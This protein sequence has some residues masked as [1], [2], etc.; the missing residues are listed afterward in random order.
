MKEN[1]YQAKV[2]NRL[3]DTFQGCLVIKNDPAYRQGIPDLLILFT[4]RWAILEV[5]ASADS[6]E[7]P[8]QGYYIDLFNSMSYA[9]FIYPENE[10]QVFDELQHALC[11]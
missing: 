7:R 9:S 3:K 5:K 1:E 4:N 11:D 6:P 2:I 10:E 8:N